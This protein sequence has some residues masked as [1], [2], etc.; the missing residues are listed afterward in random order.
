MIPAM[1]WCDICIQSKSKDDFH[2]RA[3]QKV[4]PV[5][6]FDYAVAG[7]HQGQP[8]FDFMVGT[9]MSTGAAWASAVL[10]KGRGG[11]I[12]CFIDPLMVVRARTLKSHHPVRRCTRVR[13]RHAHG[14]VKRRNDGKPTVR[15]H[16]TAITALQPPEQRRCRTDGADSYATRSKRTKSRL[17]RTQESSIK[18]D[19]PLLTWLPRHAAWQYT[20]FHKRR[21]S[22]TTAY[23]KIQ[24]HA[25]PKSNP[26]CWRSSCMQTTESIGQQ[27][28]ISMARRHL[29]RT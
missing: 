5:I 11:S 8:H 2:R 1:P 29:A 26:T 3:R 12:H 27:A 15:N 14:T 4:L 28:G 16:P 19:S 6:Q 13:S 9:D 21:D 10:I 17:R 20:R 23:E 18:D 22:T 24:T 25:L 7:T